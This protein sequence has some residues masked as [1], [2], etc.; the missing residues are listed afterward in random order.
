MSPHETPEFGLPSDG[1]LE[2]FAAELSALSPAARLDR[3]RVM[4]LAGQASVGVPAFGHGPRRWSWPVAF[5]GMTAVAASLLI[6][7]AL[8]PG[9]QVVEKVVQVPIPVHRD[10][11]PVQPPTNRLPERASSPSLPSAV[12]APSQGREQFA[13]YFDLRDR[14]LA[15]GV[16]NWASEASPADDSGSP[17][18]DYHQM[19]NRLLHEG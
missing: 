18:S 11:V 5:G 19:L 3:D 7:L 16:E 1:S 15:M 6:A 13:R 14:V 4:Y 9:P 17:P 12:S 10:V 2:R 8:Q